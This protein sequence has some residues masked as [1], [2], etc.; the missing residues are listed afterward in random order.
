MSE[1]DAP[2]IGLIGLL[3]GFR[4]APIEDDEAAEL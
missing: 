4:P 1:L 2:D 3:D